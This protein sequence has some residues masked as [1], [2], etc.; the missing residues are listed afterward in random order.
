ML[1]ENGTWCTVHHGPK[2]LL[3][4][5][6]HKSGWMKSLAS[7]LLFLLPASC[8]FLCLLGTLL[9]EQRRW[10][11]PLCELVDESVGSGPVPGVGDDAGVHPSEVECEPCLSGAVG[12]EGV[13]G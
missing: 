6:S 8:I 7:L 13:P 4:S 9:M 5:I 12:L 11:V 2:Y 3:D 10:S 1:G